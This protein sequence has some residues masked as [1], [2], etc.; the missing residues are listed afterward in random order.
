MYSVI[1]K[2]KKNKKKKKTNFSRDE[3]NV[4]IS[5]V[6]NEKNKINPLCSRSL[7][8]WASWIQNIV[9]K[10][11]LKMRK[12]INSILNYDG[13][14]AAMMMTVVHLGTFHHHIIYL[15]WTNN[16]NNVRCRFR[17]LALVVHVCAF[18]RKIKKINEQRELEV[19]WEENVQQFVHCAFSI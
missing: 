18:H 16:T 13:G 9:C 19:K 1:P 12:E 6:N 11:E 14:I 2:K 10:N 17:T 4:L 15:K 5:T 8:L 3:K 7:F